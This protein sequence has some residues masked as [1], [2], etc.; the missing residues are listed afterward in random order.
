MIAIFSFVSQKSL[1]DMFLSIKN[2]VW[3]IESGRRLEAFAVQLVVLAVWK[4]ALHIC[5]T[6]A[7]SATE[8]SPSPEIMTKESNKD[9]SNT[10]EYISSIGSKLPVALCSLI[11]KEFLLE[12]GHAEELAVDFGQIAGMVL[13]KIINDQQ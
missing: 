7:A 1:L 13:N 5:H 10:G 8:G 12:V 9:A 3:K 2:I 6:Q 4:Q 11:E